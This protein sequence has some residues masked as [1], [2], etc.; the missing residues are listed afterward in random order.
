MSYYEPQGWQAPAARQVSWEQPVPPSRSGRSGIMV[1]LYT[2]RNSCSFR[3]LGSSSISQREEMPAFSSQFDGMHKLVPILSC[4]DTRWM[5]PVS[6]SDDIE[7]F[8][9]LEKHTS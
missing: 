7:C 3:S 2:V 5:V 1:E 4:T 6:K 9:G 8:L